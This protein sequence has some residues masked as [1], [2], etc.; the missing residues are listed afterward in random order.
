M[1]KKFDKREKEIDYDDENNISPHLDHLDISISEIP[2]SI[3]KESKIR[4]DFLENK[5]DED[6]MYDQVG[7]I[8]DDDSKSISS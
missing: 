1:E 2:S 8:S 6:S 4:K 3:K 5:L 7:L